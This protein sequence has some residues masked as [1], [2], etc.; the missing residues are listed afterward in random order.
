VG[1]LLLSVS[2]FSYRTPRLVA[3]YNRELTF[4]TFL[5]FTL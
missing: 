1:D 3:T 2:S 4:Q 5:G